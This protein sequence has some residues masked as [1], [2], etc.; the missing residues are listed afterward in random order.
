MSGEKE[1]SVIIRVKDA[2]VAGLK[3]AQ[4]SVTSWANSIAGQVTQAFAITKVIDLAA[5]AMTALFHRAADETIGAQ[6]AATQLG[7]TLANVGVSLSAVRPDIDAA[8]KSLQRVA[9]VDDDEA[10]AGLSRMVQLTG[11]YR[12]S[13]KNLELVADVAAAR[14][15]SFADAAD[16]VGRVMA[17]TGSRS[18]REFGITAKDSTVALEQLR[19]KVAGASATER[20]TLEGALSH[21]NIAYG[22]MAQ[23]MGESVAKSPAFKAVL[24]EIADLLEQLAQKL[25][26]KSSG[27]NKAITFFASAALEGYAA[28]NALAQGLK[29]L[30]ILLFTP[31]DR[32]FVSTIKQA[33]FDMGAQVTDTNDKV[34]NT[35]VRMRGFGGEQEKAHTQIKK[36]TTALGEQTAALKTHVS[37]LKELIEARDRAT[38]AA[39]K[40]R[41]EDAKQR[42]SELRQTDRGRRVGMDDVQ[43]GI[44]AG[45][46]NMR[47]VDAT[48]RGMR[49]TDFAGPGPA[50]SFGQRLGLA[51]GEGTKDVDRAQVKM[52]SLG[53]V[54]ADIAA[55]PI[56]AFGD[57]MQNAFDAAIS[58]SM[59]LGKAFLQSIGSAVRNV[60]SLKGRLFAGEALAALGEG[61][62]GHPGA[63]LAAAKYGLAA[64]TMFALAGAA[65]GIGQGGG[66]GGGASTTAAASAASQ[67]QLSSV[68]RG[69]VTVYVKGKKVM[70]D[71]DDPDDQDGFI[72]MV[73]KLAGDR[74][75]ELIVDPT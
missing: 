52:E 62:L 44:A 59:S 6:R 74:Q 51:L 58:G 69:T 21:V 16:L 36:T 47:D 27:V 45:M 60:A 43:A 24:V 54:I 10:V 55:G 25:G 26:S 19:A 42:E 13:L 68:G 53:K 61:F 48:A 39:A 64:A 33:Y 12:Q 29:F 40:Q 72:A 46:P 34:L 22:D 73:K 14:Q 31:V 18:L 70:F 1:V 28:A 75:L 17:G 35:I 8:I 11:N 71:A 7:N 37:T 67:Q 9:N 3:K 65:G 49:G 15:I 38:A 32:N 23:A 2:T 20:D 50:L 4:A 41:E 66:G 57:A 5:D 56:L 63:F 30:K